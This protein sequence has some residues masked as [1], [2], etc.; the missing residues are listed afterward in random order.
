M[1]FLHLS[2]FCSSCFLCNDI[3]TLTNSIHTKERYFIFI[4]K[5]IVVGVLYP[6][7]YIPLSFAS[8][9][10]FV[11]PCF[12]FAS[13]V[14]TREIYLIRFIG[15]HVVKE[16]LEVVYPSFYVPLP[17]ASLFYFAIP[18]CTF[19][20]SI[21]IR[22]RYL[23]LIGKLIVTEFSNPLYI[24]LS[25]ALFFCAITISTFIISVHTK[26]RHFIFIRKQV[27]IEA[28]YPSLYILLSFTSLFSV[29]LH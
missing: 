14:H 23:S 10:V 25:C 1:F 6:S 21:H 22:E 4:G 2:S 17:F 29:Q 19:T 7:L 24:L 20:T 11:I 8:L 26:E 13:S 9:T 12:T 27:G 18:I 5:Q 16:V 15:K 3:S 28:F